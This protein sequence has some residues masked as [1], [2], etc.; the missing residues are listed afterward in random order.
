MELCSI[1][2][3]WHR[4]TPTSTTFLDVEDIHP[5]FCASGFMVT[6]EQPE[7]FAE[8]L[9]DMTFTSAAAICSGGEMLLFLLLPRVTR[10]LIAVDHSYRALGA[11][12]V[13]AQMLVSL[14]AKDCRQLFIEK[15][16]KKIQQ[17]AQPFK[18]ALPQPVQDA[19]LKVDNNGNLLFDHSHCMALAPH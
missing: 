9:G 17:I 13:K 18:K 16:T 2:G 8:L 10:E 19:L 3:G 5:D 14:G 4:A 11:A 7:V 6:N 15:D 1:C 12:I